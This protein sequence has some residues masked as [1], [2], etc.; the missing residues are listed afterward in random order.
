MSDDT[1]TIK[2]KKKFI[3]ENVNKL[4]T[5]DKNEIRILMVRAGKSKN[6]IYNKDGAA[7]N[8]DILDESLVTSIYSLVDHKIKKLTVSF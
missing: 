2:L 7:V 1:N 8:L 6:I 4:S 3:C 5:E